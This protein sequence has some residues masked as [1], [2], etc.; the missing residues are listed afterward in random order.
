LLQVTTRKQDE[1]KDLNPGEV[2]KE[3]SFLELDANR[4]QSHLLRDHVMK[5]S[6]DKFIPG[7]YNCATHYRHSHWGDLIFKW[8]CGGVLLPPCK[9]SVD[10]DKLSIA[11]D[12]ALCDQHRCLHTSVDQSRCGL[13]RKESCQYFCSEH[14]CRLPGCDSARL[15]DQRFCVDH[16]CKKCVSLGLSAK[17]AADDPPRNVCEDHPI[18]ILPSCCEFCAKGEPYCPEHV[19]V[20]VCSAVN[21]KR[22]PCKGTAISRHIPYCKDHARLHRPSVRPINDG[23]I[24]V[25]DDEDDIA[26]PVL[27]TTSGKCLAITRRGTPCKGVVLPGSQFCYDH[28][29][30]DAMWPEPERKAAAPRPLGEEQGARPRDEAKEPPSQE[31]TGTTV[32]INVADEDTGEKALA[33]DDDDTSASS[34]HSTADGVGD[35]P[36]ARTGDGDDFDEE[37]DEGENLQ[38]LREVFEIS[39]GQDGS[40]ND[41]KEDIDDVVAIAFQNDAGA[42]KA[43]TDTV[44]SLPPDWSWEMTLEERWSACYTFL[45]ELLGLLQVAQVQTRDAMNMARKDIR[46]AEIQAKARVYENKSIIGGTMVGCIHRLEA[47]RTTKPFAVVVEE[48]SEVLEPLLFSCLSEST[49]KLEMI[50]DHRQLSPSVQSRYDFE[51]CNKVNVSMFQRLIKAPPGH[52]IP[53]TVLSVQR[54]MRKNICDLTRSFYADVTEIEDHET[55]NSQVIGERSRVGNKLI[56]STETLG[57]EVPGIVPHVFLWTHK[58]DQR[59]SQVGV[60]RINPVEA[61]MVCSLCA[62]LVGCGV[63][64]PSIAVLTP[65]KGQLMLIRKMLLSDPRYS[66]LHLLARSQGSTDEVRASTVDRFQGDEEDVVICSLVV[67]E[68]S[69]TGFVKLVNRMIVLL[70]R[71]RLGLYILGNVGYFSES[72]MPAHWAETFGLLQSPSTND[73]DGAASEVFPQDSH[74][75]TGSELRKLSLYDL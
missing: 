30:P 46:K 22:Q 27:P 34:Y 31:A 33:G 37:E 21:K 64:R 47:I 70:S 16:A 24:G 60:S 61:E 52:A 67:D 10:C 66:S 28:A 39:D 13:P 53:S 45:Q 72:A 68:K 35:N 5:A 18:C 7:L 23:N 11:P 74:P 62:Y 55:V 15:G 4:E 58:G 43:T 36:D 8:I 29:P 6:G 69:K 9:Y 19:R 26:P 20:S 41:D 2:A 48:A 63:P 12:P 54:R 75:R 17:L 65:Y 38:H 49:V 32:S 25:D 3:L 44:V 50:G 56:S 71:A 14:C 40:F 1:T 51:L 42:T 59:K 73:T 57:R